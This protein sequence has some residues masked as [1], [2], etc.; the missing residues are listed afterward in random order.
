MQISISLNGK[1]KEKALCYRIFLH[2][3]FKRWQKGSLGF[4]LWKGL[5][6]SARELKREKTTTTTA[7]T[8][9]TTTKKAEIIVK[10]K[11]IRL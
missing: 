11:I 2:S 8:T 5:L 1:A 3:P 4:L 9:T 7:A 6:M 10:E